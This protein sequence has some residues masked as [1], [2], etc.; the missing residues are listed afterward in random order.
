MRTSGADQDTALVVVP[1][2]VL[3]VL[4]VLWFGGP[5]E[6]LRLLDQVV[7]DALSWVHRLWT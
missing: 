1:L 6:F 2:V 5:R 7:I 4:G 3:L